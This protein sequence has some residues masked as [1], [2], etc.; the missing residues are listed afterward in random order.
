M[1][2]RKSPTKKERIREANTQQRIAARLCRDVEM[3]K[4]ILGMI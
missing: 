3:L 4:T 2:G 1:T